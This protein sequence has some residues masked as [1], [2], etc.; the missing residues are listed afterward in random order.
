MRPFHSVASYHFFYTAPNVNHQEKSQHTI[1]PTPPSSLENCW[2]RKRVHIC[3]R[4]WT[5]SKPNCKILEIKA[6]RNLCWSH[7][8]NAIWL[9]S[10]RD[11]V[12]WGWG[13]QVFGDADV[14]GWKWEMGSRRGREGS[15]RLNR[16]KCSSESSSG[17]T[18]VSHAPIHTG[19]NTHRQVCP[20]STCASC[21]DIL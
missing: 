7:K 1:W 6:G 10:E 3:N 14:M 11:A 12:S 2:T 19:W 5:E 18:A 13:P 8:T 16:S 21:T 17:I 4:V 9:E 20:Q 15:W